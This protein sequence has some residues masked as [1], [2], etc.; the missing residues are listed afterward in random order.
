MKT[1]ILTIYFIFFTTWLLTDFYKNDN[2]KKETRNAM[3]FG[4]SCVHDSLL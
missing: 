4:L 3:N 1:I 2:I